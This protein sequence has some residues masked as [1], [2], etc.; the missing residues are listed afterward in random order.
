[1]K[2]S[3]N[4]GALILPDFKLCYSVTVTKTVRYSHKNRDIDQW[5]KTDGPDINAY[6]YGQLIYDERGK[7]IQ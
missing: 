2:R 6:I 5:N 3:N 4:A 1:M 7:N